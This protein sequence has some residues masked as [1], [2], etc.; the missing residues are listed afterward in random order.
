[1][2][3]L[4]LRGH[5]YDHIG[6]WQGLPVYRTTSTDSMLTD[7]RALS[8]PAVLTTL[9][10]RAPTTSESHWPAP[11]GNLYLSLPHPGP[12]QV[13]CAALSSGLGAWLSV[14]APGIVLREEWDGG[15]GAH[16]EPGGRF[17]TGMVVAEGAVGIDVHLHGRYEAGSGHVA[18]SQLALEV[19]GIEAA[20]WSVLG[21]LSWSGD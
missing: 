5:R 17:V 11:P 6:S 20:C 9:E 1:M 19:S 3:M 15:F 13:A 21:A 4:V 7:R 14:A 2:K 16:R 10:T 12:L 8:G 18:L